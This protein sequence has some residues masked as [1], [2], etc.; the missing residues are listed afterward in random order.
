METLANIT[1]ETERQRH[2]ASPYD[3]IAPPPPPP[4]EP[5]QV[6]EWSIGVGPSWHR[7]TGWLAEVSVLQWVLACASVSAVARLS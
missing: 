6:G 1:V 4:M 2:A 7:T 3:G 5:D